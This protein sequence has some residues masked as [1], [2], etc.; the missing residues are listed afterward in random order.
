M[1]RALIFDFDGTILDTETPDYET[2]VDV[3]REHGQ[4]LSIEEW[5]HT[6]GTA[7]SPLDLA[8][9]LMEKTGG[10]LSRESIH[11]RKKELFHQ[12]V[13]AEPIRSGVREYF[14]EAAG[15]GLRIG[16]AS[17]ADRSWVTGHLDRLGLLSRVDSM[18]TA[19]DVH[20]TKPDPA[21]FVQSLAALAVA[22]EEAV[23]IEDSP[24]GIRSA[25]AAGI[26]CVAVNNPITSCLDLNGADL[27]VDSLADLP[28]SYLLEHAALGRRHISWR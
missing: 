6:L 15:L 2:W 11:A 28:L 7:H 4:P 23:A 21:L 17:S 3:Y 19:E 26:F 13:L 14:T 1:I 20:L 5:A 22:P 12:R 18:R 27:R 24:N 16:V 8:A 10:R 9:N 25:R